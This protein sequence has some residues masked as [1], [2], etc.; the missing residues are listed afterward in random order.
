MATSDKGKVAIEI[1]VDAGDV[2]ALIDAFKAG[3][4]A[5]LE[6][7]ALQFPGDP[8]SNPQLGSEAHVERHRPKGKTEP[9]H[10]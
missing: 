2:Q 6:I 4:L 5:G 1:A 8:A 3:K 7:T 10:R 9:P